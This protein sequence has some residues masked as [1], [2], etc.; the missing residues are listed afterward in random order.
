MAS[1]PLPT[2]MA[3]VE[4]SVPPFR[5]PC[6]TKWYLHLVSET[7]DPSLASLWSFHTTYVIY[8]ALWILPSRKLPESLV[9]LQLYCGSSDPA[10]SADS[11]DSPCW[12]V[13]C[14]LAL[15]NP[16]APWHPG[17][18][19]D[20]SLSLIL[21]FPARQRAWNLTRD[22]HSRAWRCTLPA[23]CITSSPQSYSSHTRT[24]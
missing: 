24:C 18:Q 4:L 10:V 5:Y 15:L 8:R 3:Q 19:Y 7:Q 22:Q 9:Y 1:G 2:V 6:L 12:L 14:R 13:L 11:L 17:E 16:L 23:S 21:A 20:W